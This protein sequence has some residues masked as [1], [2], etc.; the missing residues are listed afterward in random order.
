LRQ[1]ESLTIIFKNRNLQNH[2]PAEEI[3]KYKARLVEA[4]FKLALI[5][6]GRKDN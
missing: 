1:E 2:D 5:I 4:I 6:C 3:E